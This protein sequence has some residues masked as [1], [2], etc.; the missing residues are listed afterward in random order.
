MTLSKKMAEKIEIKENSMSIIKYHRK[1]REE[2]GKEKQTADIG[3]K[4]LPWSKGKLW[5]YGYDRK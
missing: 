2:T 5:P 3:Q 4:M 1:I